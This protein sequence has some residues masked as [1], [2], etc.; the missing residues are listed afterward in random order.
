MKKSV[1]F[2]KIHEKP[3]MFGRVQG[4]GGCTRVP[5]RVRTTIT[6]GTPPH[7][8]ACSRAGHPCAP[9]VSAVRACS[10]GFFWLQR[11]GHA[12]RSLGFRAVTSG[13]TVVSRVVSQWCRTK[14]S[15]LTV[16]GSHFLKFSQNWEFINN[17]C[18]TREN[19]EFINNPCLIPCLIPV[20]SELV[21]PCCLAHG[22]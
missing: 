5:R 2:M 16:F 3:S 21:Y 11:V 20:L 7:C 14:E 9:P 19:W 15:F 22:H 10:P 4:P 17:P 8:T 12:T 1:K 13:V 18:F 6:P